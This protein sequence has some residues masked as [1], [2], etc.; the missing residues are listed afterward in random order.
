MGSYLVKCIK[1]LPTW[2]WACHLTSHLMH[3]WRAWLLMFVVCNLCQLL[4]N[5]M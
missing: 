3:S 1:D 4:L 5:N 2:A